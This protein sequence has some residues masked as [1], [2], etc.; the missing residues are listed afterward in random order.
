MNIAVIGANGFIG[1]HLSEILSKDSRNNLFL[2]GRSAIS[3][4]TN[5]NAVYDCVDLKDKDG[6]VEKF[7]NIDIVYYLAS[8]SI[9]ATTWNNPME[10]IH[11]NLIPY[12]EF[13]EGLKETKCRKI[14]FVSSAGTIY[15]TTVGKVNENSNKLPFS[16]YG[17]IKL[18]MEHFLNYYQTKYDFYFDIYR[19]SNVYGIGQDVSKGLGVI[20]IFLDNIYRE[21]KV[22]VFG[23]GTNTRN[24]IY[25]EDVVK[26]MARSI[27]SLNKSSIYNL[28]SNDTLSIN[29]LIDIMKEILEQ[30]FEVIYEE[31]RKSDNSFI[32]LDN[33]LIREENPLFEFT[34]I[35]EG[36]LATYYSISKS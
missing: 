27:N 24:Y 4:N 2:F 26:L 28:S 11:K 17:I 9:P 8:V 14:V 36:I 35:E 34:N 3:N 29:Q 7:K 6:L 31:G 21:G 32:D 18:S 33:S 25:V 5:L 30:K 15:G 12:L 20:N 1:K 16:P 13:L 23:D 19:V 10:E 22:K